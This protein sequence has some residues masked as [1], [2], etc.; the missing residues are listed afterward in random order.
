MSYT[1]VLF[2]VAGKIFIWDYFTDL[3]NSA[4]YIALVIAGLII[5]A[6]AI[7]KIL[8]KKGDSE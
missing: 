7:D 4:L 1:I 2:Y 5:I 6:D 8:N 3:D